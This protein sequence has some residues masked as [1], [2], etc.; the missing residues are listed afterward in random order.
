ML[1][2]I[3]ITPGIAPTPQETQSCFTLPAAHPTIS[4][5]LTHQPPLTLTHLLRSP[6]TIFCAATH[7]LATP[8]PHISLMLPR[9]QAPHK[10]KNKKTFF[11]LPY[12]RKGYYLQALYD[13]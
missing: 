8:I 3:R 4:T 9:L 6:Y 12:I 5:P 1:T 2:I 7:C 13:P 11:F 10:K